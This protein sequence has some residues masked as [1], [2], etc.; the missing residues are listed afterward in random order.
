MVKFE[1]VKFLGRLGIE[2]KQPFRARLSLTAV[3]D[4]YSQNN[5]NSSVYRVSKRI[6]LSVELIM[7][8]LEKLSRYE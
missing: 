6:H 5:E 2:T 7:S 8:Q 3:N 4:R 1:V